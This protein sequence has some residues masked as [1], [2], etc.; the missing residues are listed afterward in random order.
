MF[1]QASLIKLRVT[2]QRKKK[3]KRASETHTSHMETAQST[4]K[5]ATHAYERCMQEAERSLVN[6]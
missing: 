6:K 4:L 1:T 5:S 2:N 3:D